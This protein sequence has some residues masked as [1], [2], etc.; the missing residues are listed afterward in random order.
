MAQTQIYLQS[1]MGT[2]SSFR[3]KAMDFCFWNFNLRAGGFALS[4]VM[5]LA[6]GISGSFSQ[7]LVTCFGG[8]N[9]FQ[10]GYLALQ[11]IRYRVLAEKDTH[12]FPQSKY[13]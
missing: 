2:G 9:T 6:F 7:T 8:S 11:T 10:W 4:E 3:S 1:S 5:P 12:Q 13:R